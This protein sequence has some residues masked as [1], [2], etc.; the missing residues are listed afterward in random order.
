MKRKSHYT[1]TY[2]KVTPE[3]AEDGD[4]ADSGFYVAGGWDVSSRDDATYKEVVARAQAGEFDSPCEP[5]WLKSVWNT[6][7]PFNKWE[8]EACDNRVTAYG[9]PSEP[10]YRTGESTTLAVHITCASRA[11]AERVKRALIRGRGR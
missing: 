9:Y 6:V 7:G 1:I 5:G 4:V 8:V 10:D 11:S 3:S 2:D